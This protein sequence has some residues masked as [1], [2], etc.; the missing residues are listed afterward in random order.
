MRRVAQG[1]QFSEIRP[2]FVKNSETALDEPLLFDIP[3]V[4]PVFLAAPD[5]PEGQ[6]H[7]FASPEVYPI[8]RGIFESVAIA[9]QVPHLYFLDLLPRGLLDKSSVVSFRGLKAVV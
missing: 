3:F 8:C 2:D 9:L 6:V 7:I 1:L 4:L 5:L